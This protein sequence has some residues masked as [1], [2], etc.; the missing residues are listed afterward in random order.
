MGVP[1]FKET[2]IYETSSVY[3]VHGDTRHG[4]VYRTVGRWDGF[5]SQASKVMALGELFGCFGAKKIM[6]RWFKAL[7]RRLKCEQNV[8]KGVFFGR[9][10]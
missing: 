10:T 6:P 7:E 8:S 3:H 2:P 4:E 5:P 1:P 9:N